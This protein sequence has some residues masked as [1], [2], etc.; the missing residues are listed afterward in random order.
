MRFEHPSSAHV[1]VIGSGVMGAGVATAYALAGARVTVWGRRADGVVQA[2][3]TIDGHLDDV[4]ALGLL[5][6]ASRE[7]ATELVT[8]TDDLAAALQRADVVCE[9]VTEDMCLK[10]RLLAQ[11]EQLAPDDTLLTSTTSG[12]SPTSL[13]QELRRPARFVVTH[14]A[15][16]AHLVEL[17]EVVPGS[18]TADATVRAAVE[19]LAQI[20]KVG[21]EVADIPGF[22]W[23]RLQQA[24]LR[25]LV[26]LVDRGAVTPADAD[27]IVRVGYASRLPAMGPFEH[28]DLAGL[29]LVGQ[30]ADAVW[31]DLAVTPTSTDSSIAR[32]RASGRTG[33]DAGQGFYDWRQR[34]PTAFRAARDHEIVRRLRLRH[35]AE[36]PPARPIFDP[37]PMT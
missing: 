5:A 13:A 31:P 4:V 8:G 30:Q 22:L 27:Q 16:P 18:N 1:T 7:V 20:G 25:E 35:G 14:F 37:R 11:V 6:P 15:Q 28:A 19:L 10:Q 2:Q 36:L 3:R 12:L 34:D 32:L 23:S 33:I 26:G 21:V 9:A 24:V 17:V 29:D